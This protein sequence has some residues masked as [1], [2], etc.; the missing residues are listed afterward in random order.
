MTPRL[1]PSLLALALSAVAAA[2]AS[3]GIAPTSSPDDAAPGIETGVIVPEEPAFG[4]EGFYELVQVGDSTLP[5]PVDL[6]PACR[7][8]VITAALAL[9]DGRFSLSATTEEHCGAAT[10]TRSRD[11]G[12]DY[13][14]QAD[15][16][17]FVV[18][19][20]AP[21]LR[22]ESA[23]AD[24]T[25][26]VTRIYTDDGARDVRWLFRKQPSDPIIPRPQP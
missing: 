25:L 13:R 6:A 5:A 17:D 10:T 21:V 15:G 11:G 12:G 16:V 9:R 3:T 19:P 20:G 2:C 24:S 23:A 18:D 4:V 8:R 7:I 14:V 22:A 26:A 1:P